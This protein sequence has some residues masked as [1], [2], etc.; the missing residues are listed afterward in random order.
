MRQ[1]TN[2]MWSDLALRLRIE[3][4]FEVPRVERGQNLEI[5]IEDIEQSV[6]LATYAVMQ[7]TAVRT[8]TFTMCVS[9]LTRGIP[10]D[11][12]HI[13]DLTVGFID[14][15]LTVDDEGVGQGEMTMQEDLLARF[16]L[17]NEIGDVLGF[18][19]RK[20]EDHE[21]LEITQ[22]TPLHITVVEAVGW[23]LGFDS[24]CHSSF[25]SL[26]ETMF[27]SPV[28][29]ATSTTSATTPTSTR[30]SEE[31]VQKELLAAG[32]KVTEKLTFLPYQYIVIAQPTTVA[33]APSV[34]AG[35]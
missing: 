12:A 14:N 7:D 4:S 34:R 1:C 5:I 10:P 23:G 15:M 30:L 24:G 27:R 3:R 6:R 33:S 28:S 26:I 32:L 31:I 17:D 25:S 16:K 21:V 9:W 22:R 19:D 29:I 20:D 8:A 13:S 2:S 18:I 35:H 11:W